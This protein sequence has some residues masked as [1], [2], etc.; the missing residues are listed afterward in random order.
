M[1]IGDKKLKNVF[2]R[3]LT[4][5]F[6]DK[7]RKRLKLDSRYYNS[8]IKSIELATEIKLKM[9]EIIKKQRN[10]EIE[11]INNFKS[12]EEL[13]KYIA[14]QKVNEKYEKKIKEVKRE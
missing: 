10:S 11:R 6:F 13:L 8:V 7:K 14:I 3:I 2:Y 9:Q 1:Y 12:S 4:H 5:I